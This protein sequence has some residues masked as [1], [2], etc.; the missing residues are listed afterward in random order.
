VLYSNTTGG[1]N[2]AHGNQSLSANT[3][4]NANV[5][6]GSKALEVKIFQMGKTIVFRSW[7]RNHGIRRGWR[8]RF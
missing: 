3:T 2:N 4:G 5:A 7:I 8:C 6:N 1:F